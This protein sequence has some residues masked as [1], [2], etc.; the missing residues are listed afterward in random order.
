MARHLPG[1]PAATDVYPS[2]WNTPGPIPG[3]DFADA[4]EWHA[5][6]DVSGSEQLTLLMSRRIPGEP[7]APRCDDVQQSDV[8]CRSTV[9]DDGSTEVSFGFV[10]HDTTYRFLNL[11]VTPDGFVTEA[12][13]DVEAHSWPEARAARELGGEETTALLRDPALSFP[14]PV[15][16]PPPP[17][18]G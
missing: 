12:L 8:P 3:A 14:A 2:D 11:H 1:L 16:T 17:T 9:G 5:V 10:L 13:D 4:T 7:M 15:H 18:L 6:Y